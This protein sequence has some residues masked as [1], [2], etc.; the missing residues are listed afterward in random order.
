MSIVSNLTDCTMYNVHCT[1]MINFNNSRYF[2]SFI[3]YLSINTRSRNFA[4]KSTTLPHSLQS[5]IR[6]IVYST[7]YLLLESIAFLYTSSACII[8]ICV[9]SLNAVIVSTPTSHTIIKDMR[10]IVF[11]M[12]HFHLSMYFFS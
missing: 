12:L 3:F 11:F 6:I 5:S 4:S 10:K 8:S 2:R 7:I 1:S 9:A